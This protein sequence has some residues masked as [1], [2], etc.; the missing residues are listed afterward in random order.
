MTTLDGL[1]VLYYD[2]GWRY[3]KLLSHD[4]ITALIVHPVDGK[5]RVKLDNCKV[6][7]GEEATRIAD[8]F[9]ASKASATPTGAE[10]VAKTKKTSKKAETKVRAGS[11]ILAVAAG[12]ELKDF[13][14]GSH[15]YFAVK[16]LTKLGK[17]TAAEIT[18]EAIAQGFKTTMDPA[19]AIAWICN[20]LFT[21]KKFKQAGETKAAE[22]AA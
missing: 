12:T 13:K 19:K 3:A 4:G 16:A 1:D 17:G 20:K 15:G 14:E 9:E 7:R 5:K 6:Y 18:A 21:E 10:K 22:A 2:E 11:R 8:F